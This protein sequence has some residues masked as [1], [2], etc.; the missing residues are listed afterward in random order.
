VVITL[1]HIRCSTHAHPLAE[2]AHENA[3]KDTDNFLC[4]GI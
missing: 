4:H 1:E 2:A 3:N